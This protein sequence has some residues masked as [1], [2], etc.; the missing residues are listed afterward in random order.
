M[1]AVFFNSK[2]NGPARA[3]PNCRGFGG[4]LLIYLLVALSGCT[5]Q[6][7]SETAQPASET[8]QPASETAQP[9]TTAADASGEADANGERVGTVTLTIESAGDEVK[10][11]EVPEVSAGTTLEAVMRSLDGI[12]VEITGSG[13]TAFVNAIGNRATGGQEGWTFKVNGEP[14]NQGIGATV[15]QPPVEIVWSYGSFSD[16]L[17]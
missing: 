6:P 3:L 5:A 13:T 14:A 1:R 7:A 15:L 17:E 10:V 8:A 11:I 2:F 4:A 16:T 9:R 12:D